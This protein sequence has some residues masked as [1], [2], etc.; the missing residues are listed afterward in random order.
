[1][2]AR[3]PVAAK[4]STGHVEM[5]GMSHERAQPRRVVLSRIEIHWQDEEGASFTSAAMLEDTSRDGACIR[6]R[7]PVATGTKIRAI[8]QGKEFTGT[9]RY[10]RTNGMGY[11]IGIL[12]DPPSPA[13]EQAASEQSVSEHAVPEPSTAEPPADPNPQPAIAN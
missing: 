13:P 5:L 9:V 6:V 4:E 8:H 11:L 7:Q 1:M 12:K 2:K 10:C 3:I